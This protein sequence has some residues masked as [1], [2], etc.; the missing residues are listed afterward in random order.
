LTRAARNCKVCGANRRKR[1][2]KVMK[3]S[4]LRTRFS[5]V[6]R[7]P[8]RPAVAALLGLTGLVMLPA[9]AF[10]AHVS[11]KLTGYENSTPEASRELHF[12]NA[13]THDIYLSPSHADGSFA[14]D[15]PPG[16]YDLRG[17]RGVILKDSIAVGGD[18]VSL[19]IVSEAA[20]YAPARLFDLQ[21]LAP[22][23]LTSPAP[24]TA[25]IMTADTTV[26]SSSAVLVPKR[27][28]DWSKPS[29][30]EA[31]APAP[32]PAA[33]PPISSGMPKLGVTPMFPGSQPNSARP[34][35]QPE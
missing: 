2:L 20:P 22:S 29:G 34:G 28:I 32:V 5:A 33:P 24:S 6:T 25:Y 23:I 21:A 3:A 1:K 12:Q 13:I 9:A 10:A 31:E 17:E 14:A 27:E 19:G 26:P 18:D 16:V 4:I 35:P 15:L 7:R 8:A 30:G 11:G